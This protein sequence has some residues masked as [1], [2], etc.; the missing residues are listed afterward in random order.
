MNK[1]VIDGLTIIAIIIIGF[2]LIRWIRRLKSTI[3]N[4]SIVSNSITKVKKYT[5]QNIAKSYLTGCSW[6][7]SNITTSSV[8]F[9]FRSN[10][11]LLVTKNGIVQKGSY[12]FII[13][14]N[15]ILIT[16]DG[17]TEHY[18]IKHITNNFLFLI[19][20]STDTELVFYNHSKYKDKEMEFILHLAQK[21]L[22][23]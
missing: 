11:D 7:L 1:D 20:L 9:T 3:S 8:I 21:E 23:S 13:D 12:E 5:K 4:D 15:S 6:N 19:K 2:F 22:N 14:D 10:S 18:N 16:R 17:I